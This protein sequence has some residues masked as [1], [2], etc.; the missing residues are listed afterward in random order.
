MIENKRQKSVK[1]ANLEPINQHCLKLLRQARAPHPEHNLH[2]M[3]LL[4]WALETKQIKIVIEAL[5]GHLNSLL[6][7][8]PAHLMNYLNL[9]SMTLK[10][11]PLDQAQQV[12]EELHGVVT[13]TVQ[14]YPPKKLENY[15]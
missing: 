1:K 15:R 2:A 7:A 12:L 9:R 3:N 13:E 8:H 5:E 11:K 4:I 10:A 14:G 6:G